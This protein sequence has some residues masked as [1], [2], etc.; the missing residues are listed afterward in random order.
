MSVDALPYA[1]GGPPLRGTLRAK[2]ADFFVDEQLGFEPTGSGE[3]FFVQVEKAGANTDWVAKQLAAFAGVPAMAVSWSGMKDRHAVTRQWFSVQ[4]PG[5]GDPDWSS[6]AIEGVSLLDAR[7]HNRKLKRGVH[8]GN[9]FRI[10]L[11]AIS[12]DRDAAQALIEMIA[13]QGVPHYFGEQ[14]FGRGGDNLG[15]ARSLFA[16]RRLPRDQRGFALS[17]A[18][19]YLFNQVLAA[20]VEDG[21]WNRATDGDVFMLA[22]THSVFGPELIDEA[23]RERIDRLDIHPTGAMW[24][25]G[26][27]RSTGIVG[28]LESTIAEADADLV[29]GLVKHELDQQRRALRLIAS[30][31]IT[32]WE[33]NDLILDFG[34]ESG[35]FATVVIR[36]LCN[37]STG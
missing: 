5:K 23:L 4:L 24:G 10:R 19:S 26:D 9:R 35:A 14:R 34:L 31:L 33:G 36:E 21:T 18:R 37:T 11:R 20:R 25:R 8:R 6:L 1:Y 12:G 32:T 30:D 15:L 7:R 2:P 13:R 22:G 29:A 16:G 27:L 17:A 3:H 28:E